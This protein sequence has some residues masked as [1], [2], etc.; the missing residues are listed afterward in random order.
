VI[1]FRMS[2]P[3][4]SGTA[5]ATETGSLAPVSALLLYLLME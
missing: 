5:F 3:G 1:Q 2:L 4:G